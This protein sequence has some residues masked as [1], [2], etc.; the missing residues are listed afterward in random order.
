MSIHR[1]ESGEPRVPLARNETIRKEIMCFLEG[2]T[3]SAREI[4]AEVK[5]PEKEVYEHLEHIQK[6]SHKA[7]HHLIVVPAECRKCGFVF[8]KRERLKKPGRCPVCRGESIQE[9]YFS[10]Q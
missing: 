10:L 9:P 2:R 5:I 6:T 4:S 1:E 3:V 8:K 7:A